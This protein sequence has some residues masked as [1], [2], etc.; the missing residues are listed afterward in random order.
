MSSLFLL[1]KYLKVECLDYI[2]DACLTF[3]DP[4]E[5]FLKQVHLLTFLSAV[6][7]DSSCSTSSSTLGLVR[8]FH[9]CHSDSHVVVSPC[10]F[11]LYFPNYWEWI[12]FH[13]HNKNL[14]IFFDEVSVQIFC[15]FLI[16]LFITNNTWDFIIYSRYKSF[17]RHEIYKYLIPLC[18]LSFYPLTV[19]FE[20]QTFVILIKSNL[21]EF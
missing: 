5:Q 2:I 12:S 11:N 6:Y 13:V 19:S 8:L 21:A 7:E 15:Q 9:F 16:E 10:S 17:I 20:R 1:D 4:S 18:G 3:L 14:H